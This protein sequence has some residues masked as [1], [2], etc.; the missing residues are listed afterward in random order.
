MSGTT[1]T[2]TGALYGSNFNTAG[3]ATVASLVSNGAITGTTGT[4]TSIQNSGNQRSATIVS[5]TWI[6]ATQNLTVASSNTSTTTST[7]ALVVTGGIGAG[8]NVNAG[9]NLHYF[10]GTVG[11]GHV[12]TGWQDSTAVQLK[13][14]TSGGA[15]VALAALGA[16]DIMSLVRNLYWDGTDWRHNATDAASVY[17]QDTT[18]SHAW[19]YA[20][21]A[22]AGNIAVLQQTMALTNTG[23]LFVNAASIDNVYVSGTSESNSIATGAVVIVGGVGIGGNL[24]VGGNVVVTGQIFGTIATDVPLVLNDVSNQTNGLKAVFQLKTNQ[25]LYTGIVDSKNLEVIVNGQRLSPHVTQVTYPWFST[26]YGSWPGYRVSGSNVII[27]N[28]PDKGSRVSLTVLNKSTTKQTQ[29]YP[30]LPTTI[31]LGD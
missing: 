7:G 8:G 6:H 5:N 27:Y 18:G 26:Y 30:F 1:G 10:G 29:R 13:A 17:Q 14:G 9:G 3:T 28:A 24:Q 25:T 20:P 4:F 2:F 21:F 22:N 23:E 16:D 15:T 11:V 31:V 19:G 12:P